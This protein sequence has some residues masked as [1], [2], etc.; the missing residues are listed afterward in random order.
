[1][2]L[3]STP[4]H[5]EKIHGRPGPRARCYIPWLVRGKLDPLSRHTPNFA[6]ISLLMPAERPSSLLGATATMW[7]WLACTLAI[8]LAVVFGG[9]RLVRPPTPTDFAAQSAEDSQRSHIELRLVPERLPGSIIASTPPNRGAADIVTPPRTHRSRTSALVE[10]RPTGAAAKPVASEPVRV[11][12]PIAGH[13][14]LEELGLMPIPT[15]S[16][17]L[18]PA[19]AVDSTQEPHGQYR[20]G[21]HER[22]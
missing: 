3:D 7:P 12:V 2:L 1:M 11:A 14:E 17:A 19:T 8:T 13:S 5:E 22:T 6:E 4:E 15:R 16:H 9:G 10:Q 20:A 21:H 18:E